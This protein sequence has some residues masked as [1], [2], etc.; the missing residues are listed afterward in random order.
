MSGAG[1]SNTSVP[2][3]IN[4]SYDLFAYQEVC[5]LKCRKETYFHPLT[6]KGIKPGIQR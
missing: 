6:Y 4:G 1:R 2:N 5:T 3:L